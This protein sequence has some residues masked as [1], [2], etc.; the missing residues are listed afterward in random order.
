VLNVPATGR[1][2][3]IAFPPS[4]SLALNVLYVTSLTIAFIA[5]IIHLLISGSR[6]GYGLTAIKDDEIA[7]EAIGVNSL[8]LKVR[9]FWIS[10]FIAGLA[11]TLYPIF[12]SFITPDGAFSVALS[13]NALL[14]ALLG[15]A[16]FVLGAIIGATFLVLLQNLLVF[17]IGGIVYLVIFGCLLSMVV[18]FLP[19]GIVG[20]LRRRFRR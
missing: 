5:I 20:S 10:A 7:A 3:G 11:G 19:A 18:M 2:E 15:G 12:V 14:A 6:F 4:A 13:L 8:S 1:G 9:T 17:T 16:G